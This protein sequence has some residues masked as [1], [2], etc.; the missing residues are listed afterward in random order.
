[1]PDGHYR[2]ETVSSALNEVV[3]TNTAE[4]YAIVSEVQIKDG[5][6][7]LVLSGGRTVAASDVTA[8][9]DAALS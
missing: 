8:V 2:F 7:T 4:V 3:A 9:R 6:N 1:M 5:I